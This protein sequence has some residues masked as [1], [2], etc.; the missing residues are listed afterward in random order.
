MKSIIFIITGL[1]IAIMLMLA[2]INLLRKL[3]KSKDKIIMDMKIRYEMKKDEKLS[4]LNKKIIRN[5]KLWRI[6]L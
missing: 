1:I 2:Y 3:N 4:N 5:N 6:K